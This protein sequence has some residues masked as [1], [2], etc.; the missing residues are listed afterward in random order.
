MEDLVADSVAMRP[1]PRRLLF[2]TSRLPYPPTEGHQLRSWH[3]LRAAA[4]RHHVHLLS[5]L[6][7]E[8]PR[9]LAPEA[10]RLVADFEGIAIADALPRQALAFAGSLAGGD[11]FVVR[12]YV[13]RALRERFAKRVHSC[14]FV[15]L[16]MLPLA[17][18]APLAGPRPVVLNEHNVEH[19]LAASRAKLAHGAKRLALASQLPSLRRFEREACERATRVLACSDVD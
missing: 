10:R 18:L 9:E 4:S 3:L 5:L 19:V 7:P 11:P 16:D 6:R 14:D 12:K 15:H 17:A 8:D 1:S 13:T 2:V